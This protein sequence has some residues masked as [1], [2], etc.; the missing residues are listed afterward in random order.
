MIR[1][2]Y[3]KYFPGMLA[4]VLTQLSCNKLIEKPYSSIFTDNFYKTASDA[5]AGLTAVY[6]PMA[7]LY[8]TAGTFAS[9]FSADQIYPRPVV[10]RDTYTL[11]S[12]DPNYTTQKSFSR[13]FE[14]PQQIWESCYSGIEKANWVIVKVPQTTM[15]VTRRTAILGEA[16]YMRA[17]YTWTLTKNFGDVVVKTGEQGD[18]TR[19]QDV[20]RVEL[21]ARDYSTKTYMDGYNAVSLRVFQLPGSNSVNRTNGTYFLKRLGWLKKL[22]LAP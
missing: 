6:G 22:R 16:Y 2:K 7:G 19:V 15:D 9:D 14:S 5:E 18:V 17:F 4:I 10:G 8:N 21:G 3:L 20:A 1:T 13:Q 12:Y 11:F